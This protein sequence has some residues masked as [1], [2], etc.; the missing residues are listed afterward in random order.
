MVSEK[1]TGTAYLLLVLGPWFGFCGLQRF[2]VGHIG[3]GILY[4]LT[5]GLLGIGQLMDLFIFAR[6]VEN[7]NLKIRKQNM[8]RRESGHV[9]LSNQKQP[10]LAQKLLNIKKLNPEE[11]ERVLLKFIQSK[12]GMITPI[13]IASASSLSMDQ[14]KKELDNF[15]VNSAAEMRITDSGEIVYVFFGFLSVEQKRKAKSLLSA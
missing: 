12:G 14:A 3:M 7:H 1:S 8:T 11:R 10:T 4:V 2:Y 9:G 5:F 15:C 13:E 6:V